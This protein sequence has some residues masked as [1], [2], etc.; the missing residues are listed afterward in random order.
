AAPQSPPSDCADIG[1]RSLSPAIV[2]VCQGDEETKLAEAER[3]GERTRHLVLAADHFRRAADLG[4]GALKV[5]ALEAAARIY[6]LQH[7]NDLPQL[8]VVLRDLIAVAPTESRFLY[9]LAKV[10]KDR[11]LFDAAEDTL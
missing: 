4:E 2:Q 7:L 1:V 10:Q 11:G 9:A 5:R 6:D 3:G 8:E